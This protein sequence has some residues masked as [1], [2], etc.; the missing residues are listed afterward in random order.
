[1][2]NISGFFRLI[3][4]AVFMLS[5]GCSGG[6]N[7]MG[8]KENHFYGS[9]QDVPDSEWKKLSQQTIFFGHQ[10]VGYN[11]IEGMQDVIKE[12]PQIKLRFTTLD[13]MDVSEKE[14]MFVH[15]EIGTNRNP[16][17]KIDEFSAILENPKGKKFDIAFLKFC[18]I[19]IDAE[20]DISQ[21]FQQ[22]RNAMERLK[23]AYP[24]TKIFHLTVPLSY[25]KTTWKTWLKKILGKDDIWEYDSNI[26]KNQYNDMV[27]Q[28][29]AE[30][31]P[32]FDLAAVESTLPDGTRSI[33]KKSGQVYYQL[34]PEYTFDDGHL[35][36]VGRKIVA[37]QFL[38][39]LVNNQ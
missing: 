25:N 24:A 1:M 33:F 31:G 16:S 15:G 7:D 36:E 17:S 21:L 20:T 2:I 6:G 10:S 23:K 4:L 13:A 27:R 14:G 8:K 39:F 22:Y 35:N 29:Y 26:R 32:L 38:L 5:P 9:L 11:I 12:N 34:A 30:K 3:L 19:D 28:H 37:E 18:F